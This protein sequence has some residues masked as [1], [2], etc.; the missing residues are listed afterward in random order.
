MS[1]QLLIGGE[2]AH[3][4]PELVLFDK[5]G[6]IIDIHHYW[7]SMI[8]IR[9]AMIIDRWFGAHA[10]RKQIES[11]LINAMGVNLQ[12][13]RI[14]AEGPVGIEPRP[15]IVNVAANV[16]RKRGT[17]IEN[18]AMENLFSRVDQVT[19]ED[20]QPLLK[21]L[22]GVH[23][24]LQRLKENGIV[25]MVVSTDITQRA[26]KAMEVLQLDRYFDDIIG[27]DQVS[28]TKPSAD[29]ALLALERSGCAATGAVVIGDHP[30]DMKMGCAAEVGLN[31]G[32]LTGLSDA[33]MFKGMDC[34]VV[35]DLTAIKIET[36]FNG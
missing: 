35:A 6:T 5:D 22:P 11:Q 18:D 1:A 26:R 31:I 7:A 3:N 36:D 15:F 25:S 4:A 27:A 10:D 19:A 29:L 32:V 33:A 24:L 34:R 21:L 12:S 28:H 13:G 30:V 9:S 2:V 16:V 17:N 23:S 14:K 20:I 8:R